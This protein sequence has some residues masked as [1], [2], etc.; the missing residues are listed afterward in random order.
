V[1]DPARYPLR[2]ERFPIQ[3]PL[4]YR[5]SGEL[6]WHSGTTINISSAGA[7][8]RAEPETVLEM[9]VLFPAEVTGEAPAKVVCWGPVV[10]KVVSDPAESQPALAAAIF[11]YRFS[12][13]SESQPVD[14]RAARRTRRPAY[15]LAIQ[16][17]LAASAVVAALVFSLLLRPLM[18]HSIF[19]LFYSAVLVTA[20]FESRWGPGLFAAISSAILVNYFFFH[21]GR[22]LV[23]DLGDLVR[24]S[25][26]MLM[27][28]LTIFV[29]AARRRAEDALHR[30]NGE[31]DTRVQERTAEL[32]VANQS[33]QFE[34]AE[35]RQ[36]EADLQVSEECYRS[37]FDGVPVGLYRSTPQGQILDANLAMV[38]ILG[39]PDRESLLAVDINN[40]FA[41][42]EDRRRWQAMFAREKTVR[43][44]KTRLLRYDGTP[45]WVL[46]GAHAF[47]G[48][49]GRVQYY[50]GSLL[51]ITKRELAE[52]ALH[53]S[54]ER[55]RLIAETIDEVFWMGEIGIERFFYASPAC[56]H[57]W[58]RSRKSQDED[59]RS[60]LESIHPE[61]RERVVADLEIE[62]TGR[63][64]AHE[65]RIVRPDGSIRYIWDRGFPV[66]DET[67]KITC[68]VGVAQDITERKHIE[69]QSRQNQ[70]MEAIGTLA[71]GVAHDFSN[72][73][74]VIN[75]Y[76][77]L[78]LR[79]L[80]RED[81]RRSD[82]EEIHRA[83]QRAFS[84]TSQLLAFGRKQVLQPRILDLNDVVTDMGRMLRRLLGEEIQLV[85]LTLP[86]LGRVKADP[87]QIQQIFM[88]LAINAR[89]AMPR[90]GKLTIET[91]NVD[92][93][94]D[95]VRGHAEVPA[96]PYVML[97][98]SDNGTG[99]DAETRARIFEPFFTT[100]EPGKG[101][102]LGLS[103]VH[104][105]VKQSG[106]FIVVDSELG[107]GATFKIYLPREGE[108]A[109]KLMGLAE[110]KLSLKGAETVLVVEDERSVRTLAVRV[111]REQGYTVLEASNGAE[112][113]RMDQEFAGEIHLVL[114]DVVMPEMSG[115]ALS[116][117]IE[118]AR[119]SI[120][121]LYVS[122]YTSDV[123]VRH[124]VLGSDVSFLQKP[125]TED[126]LA[127]KVR[128]VLD[129]PALVAFE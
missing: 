47:Y 95:C 7:L 5:K 45:I 91:A 116:S 52:E 49:D 31:M 103:T 2:P 63:P 54:E 8:F 86:G 69:D 126:A 33:L 66:R 122:G 35:R 75:G 113:L 48:A 92:L 51:D 70:K 105:V 84:L 24:S 61:D 13:G 112:A 97:A 64:F 4:H 99:M 10:R 115:K 27:A 11:S 29:S 40:T 110:E 93:G 124:G 43:D 90:G 58:G 21:P 26:F 60:F 56:E 106:G 120:K 59:P 128:K 81:P 88:N 125:F 80:A 62:K 72:L 38:R 9:R 18:Q 16:Y 73:L 68:Y 3:T 57:I 89:D 36:A 6:E 65:Y 19:L 123:I 107:K 108:K 76:S 82:L 30:L 114:T 77:S 117:Q 14:E 50:G 28:L 87:G 1:P 79:D 96:G 111:L 85:V 104:G 83:G 71:G 22:A 37:L 74:T 94:E 20:W 109:S 23:L 44:F 101:T 39:Y 129:S 41:D 98:V 42:P 32:T 55:F 46:D 118:A 67:G 127:R 25:I 12:P 34:I 119:P 100:K 53:E 17:G 15:G 121:V 78:L 102:G